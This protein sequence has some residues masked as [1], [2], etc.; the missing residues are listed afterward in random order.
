VGKK[1][2]F[3][4]FLFFSSLLA[5]VGFSLLGRAVFFFLS[6]WIPSFP[7]DPTIQIYI[8]FNHSLEVLFFFAFFMLLIFWMDLITSLRGPGSGPS[9]TCQKVSLIV[10]ITFL[11]GV[12]LGFGGL[13]L[14]WSQGKEAKILYLDSYFAGLVS[15]LSVMV[16]VMFLIFG[17]IL[18]RL[19]RKH[20]QL[21]TVNVEKKKQMAR[22]IFIVTALCI[23]CFGFRVIV[24]IYSLTQEWTGDGVCGFDVPPTV[25]F[26][27][28]FLPEIAG[29]SLMLVLLRIP[30]RDIPKMNVQQ[31][32]YRRIV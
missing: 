30:R 17:L 32:N 19:L 25:F 29:S 10:F 9:P 31:Q 16:S 21:L 2:F 7:K 3:F 8:W 23:V 6:P 27:Y 4:I 11:V 13:F 28:F 22:N 1:R 26:L 12:V 18:Y 20:D 14:G 5:F 24:T 15:V